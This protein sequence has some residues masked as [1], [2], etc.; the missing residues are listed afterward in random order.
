M[1]EQTGVNVSEQVSDKGEETVTRPAL[2]V[3]FIE[4]MVSTPEDVLEATTLFQ[5]P[6][7]DV[8]TV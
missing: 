7:V 1:S 4:P 8:S 2:K 3:P 5:G 6:T